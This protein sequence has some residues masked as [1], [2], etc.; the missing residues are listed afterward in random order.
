MSFVE[1]ELGQRFFRSAPAGAPAEARDWNPKTLIIFGTAILIIAWLWPVAVMLAVAVPALIL[2]S[3]WL[4]SRL[5]FRKLDQEIDLSRTTPLARKLSRALRAVN[6]A[7]TASRKADSAREAIALLDEIARYP[8]AAARFVPTRRKLRADLERITRAM[9]VVGRMAA[10][11]THERLGQGQACRA[12][13]TEA[14]NLSHQVGLTDED[15]TRA[16]AADGDRP[17]TLARIHGRA[18]Q[19][20]WRPIAPTTERRSVFDIRRYLR[21]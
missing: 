20:G 11:G 15:L 3:G 9:P 5:Q 13:L 1:F 6:H 16:N 10:A 2:A 12:A 8:H 7:R 18:I 19:A 14:A 21:R 4:R 17:L